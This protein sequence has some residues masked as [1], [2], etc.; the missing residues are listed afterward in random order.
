MLLCAM[1]VF[2][3]ISE[4]VGRVIFGTRLV[5]ED[6]FEVCILRMPAINK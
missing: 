4:D 1:Q 3:G 2:R 6:S 5:V